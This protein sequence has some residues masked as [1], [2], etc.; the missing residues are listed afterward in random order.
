MFGS[1]P[2]PN[3]VHPCWYVVE[4]DARVSG[5]SSNRSLTRLS[6]SVLENAI[7]VRNRFDKYLIFRD[8]L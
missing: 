1:E 4:Y 7:L 5:W 6:D 8:Y 3:Q 2:P